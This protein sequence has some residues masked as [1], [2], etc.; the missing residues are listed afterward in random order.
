MKTIIEPFRITI[1]E[2]LRHAP[3]EHL[4]PGIAG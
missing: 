3:Q 1:V 2:P 4:R